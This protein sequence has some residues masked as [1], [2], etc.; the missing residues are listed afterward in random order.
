LKP[1]N[2]HGHYRAITELSVGKEEVVSV[3][4][5]LSVEKEATQRSGAFPIVLV[6]V[7]DR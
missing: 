5:Q 1:E 2:F 4:R 6:L 7:S 3:S